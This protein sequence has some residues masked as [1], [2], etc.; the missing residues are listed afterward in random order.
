MHFGK[1]VV[2]F[3]KQEGTFI[4]II[5]I[6]ITIIIIIIII[7]IILIIVIINNYVLLSQFVLFPWERPGGSDHLIS[8]DHLSQNMGYAHKADWSS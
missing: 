7:I 3:G 8:R 2:A 1:Q 5:I 4:I 6:I